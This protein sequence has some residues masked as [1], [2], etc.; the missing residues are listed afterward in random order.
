M[1]QAKQRKTAVEAMRSVAGLANTPNIKQARQEG[2]KMLGHLISPHEVDLTMNALA[3]EDDLIVYSLPVT[4]D[5]RDLRDQ[6]LAA[7]LP[8]FFKQWGEHVN[9]VR[10]G[11]KEAGRLLDEREWNEFPFPDE[12]YVEQR[13]E[14]L[15]FAQREVVAEP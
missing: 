5:Q 10:V 3:V 4:A 6:C 15:Y 13:E 11:K 12:N 9:L 1:G 7:R 2:K 14:I 8:F